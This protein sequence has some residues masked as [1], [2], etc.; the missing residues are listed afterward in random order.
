MFRAHRV[1]PA[2]SVRNKDHKTNNNRATE[3]NGQT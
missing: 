1:V 2:L 3:E